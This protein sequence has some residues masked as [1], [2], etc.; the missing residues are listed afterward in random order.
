[1]GCYV[2]KMAMDGQYDDTNVFRP[3]YLLLVFWMVKIVVLLKDIEFIFYCKIDSNNILHSMK[4]WSHTSPL[5]IDDRAS[6]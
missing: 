4:I 5:H 2:T 3:K 1:M 6:C